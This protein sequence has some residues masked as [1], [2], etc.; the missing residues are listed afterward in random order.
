MGSKII[1]TAKSSKNG[2]SQFP[3][4]SNRSFSFVSLPSFVLYTSRSHPTWHIFSLPKLPPPLTSGTGLTK[5]PAAFH[6]SP[7]TSPP[8]TA[9]PSR[10]SSSGH[11]RSPRVDSNISA[12]RA[13]STRPAIAAASVEARSRSSSRYRG[14]G[15]TAP[16]EEQQ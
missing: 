15:R 4:L 6:T 8:N 12:T 13:P 14:T 10:T 11:A 5:S 7:S 16:G 9:M 1:P 2:S 3:Y